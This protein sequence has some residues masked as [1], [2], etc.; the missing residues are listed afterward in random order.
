MSS[1]NKAGEPR[2]TSTSTKK[3]MQNEEKK[4]KYE[5]KLVTQAKELK[6]AM[7]NHHE[8]VMINQELRDRNLKR[9]KQ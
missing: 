3:E 4:E 6:E 9:K 5:E 2:E 8:K 1:Q 7:K